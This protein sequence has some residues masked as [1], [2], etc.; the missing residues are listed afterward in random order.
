[1]VLRK[2]M[3]PDN[4][5]D[6]GHHNND[7][8]IMLHLMAIKKRIKMSIVNIQVLIS[9]MSR[10]TATVLNSSVFIL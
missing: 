7:I 10:T 8:F 2:V 3:N 6:N 9:I 1:M 4:I 5:N